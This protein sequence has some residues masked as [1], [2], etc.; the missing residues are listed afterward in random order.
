MDEKYM[1]EARRI[2]KQI[3]DAEKHA[4]MYQEVFKQ[5]A[6]EYIEQLNKEVAC[7]TEK[8]A[9]EL[10]K[11]REELEQIWSAVKKGNIEELIKKY[12]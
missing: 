5:Q 12:R 1:Q 3:A 2:R 7:E 4:A 10:Q 8:R 9:Q 11:S 6:D